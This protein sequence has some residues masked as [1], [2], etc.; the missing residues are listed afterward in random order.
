MHAA[1]F[2]PFTIRTSDG[3]EYVVR[4]SDHAAVHPKVTG[5]DESSAKISSL[6]VAALVEPT[7]GA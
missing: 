2:E 7:D 4:T 5:D 6:H 3:R 1:P